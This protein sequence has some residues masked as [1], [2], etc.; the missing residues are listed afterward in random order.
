VRVAVA[1]FCFLPLS[2]DGD[3]VYDDSESESQFACSKELFMFAL[4]IIHSTAR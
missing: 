1:V 4:I 2:C 3:A